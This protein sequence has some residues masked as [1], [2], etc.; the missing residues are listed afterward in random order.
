MRGDA[1]SDSP[2]YCIAPP[3]TGGWIGE[4]WALGFEQRED[5]RI[6]E[7]REWGS[8]TKRVQ[9]NY[10]EAPRL[11]TRRQALVLVLH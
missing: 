1:E 3:L 4:D 2:Q 11:V 6:K 10:M 9:E 5:K 8:E 7:A